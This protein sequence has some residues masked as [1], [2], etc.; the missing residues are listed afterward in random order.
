MNC[1]CRNRCTGLRA[2]VKLG[3]GPWAWGK[4]RCRWWRRWRKQLS[5]AA[6]PSQP[7]AVPELRKLRVPDQSKNS[8][9]NDVGV[10]GPVR[11]CKARGLPNRE[12]RNVGI[13]DSV[14]TSYVVS[15]VVWCTLHLTAPL[16]GR[17]VALCFC[18]AVPQRSIHASRRWASLVQV[19]I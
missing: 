4:L 1:C 16:R 18:L 12:R 11:S 14:F 8:F 6:P 19:C 2:P 15:F 13:E 7:L 17:G 9:S 5:S 10:H 3:V